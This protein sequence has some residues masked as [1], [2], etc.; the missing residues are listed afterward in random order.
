MDGGFADSI[1]RFEL[2]AQVVFSILFI[3]LLNMYYWK[4]STVV[5][6]RKL[7]NAYIKRKARLGKITLS[8]AFLLLKGLLMSLLK[9][10]EP[11]S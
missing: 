2:L 6:Y 1:K 7:I 9:Y 4:L 11:S 5:S 8:L 10:V 3:V